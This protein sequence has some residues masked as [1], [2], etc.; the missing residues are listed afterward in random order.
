MHIPTRAFRLLTNP[1]AE[2]RSIAVQPASTAQ[3]LTYAAVLALI[4]PLA[5]FIGYSVIGVSPGMDGT[6]LRMPIEWGLSRA[7]LGYVLLL[8]GVWVNAMLIEALAPRFQGRAD[9]NTALKL[10]A[11]APTP[12][13]LAGIFLLVPPIGFLSLLGLY[14]IYVL[15]V[16]LPIIARVP[17][18]ESLWLVASIVTCYAIVSILAVAVETF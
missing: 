5:A 17:P 10:A 4:P 18:D 2:W 15:T 3:L 16:G 1:G 6:R 8:V 14:S 12:L 11:Y 13:W 7:V 9:F